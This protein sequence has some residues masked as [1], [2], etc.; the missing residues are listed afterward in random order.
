MSRYYILTE[1]NGV[2]IVEATRV[3]ESDPFRIR[4]AAGSGITSFDRNELLWWSSVESP[5]PA[6]FA[7]FD[8]L[9]DAHPRG[10]LGAHSPLNKQPE[11][12][13][14]VQRS[15]ALGNRS[16]AALRALVEA[17]RSGVP[18]GWK[19]AVLELK[20]SY[21]LP[22]GRYKVA[23]RLLNPDGEA[24]A[25]DFSDALFASIEVFHRIAV[26]EGQNWNR[27]TLTLHLDDHGGC[28]AA[29]LNH[30]YGTDFGPR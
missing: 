5:S 27:S 14:E 4:F 9:H 26:E 21:E 22:E 30:E 3:D 17:A 28:N 8:Q 13:R 6:P 7:N 18:P 1:R 19:N 20:V 10:G 2:E 29:E 23:H 16:A 25:F 11:P 24:E 12:M 15:A